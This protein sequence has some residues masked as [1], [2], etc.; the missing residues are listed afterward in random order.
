MTFHKG[1]RVAA[2]RW[3]KVCHGTV[4][5][6]RVPSIVWVVWDGRKTP[7]W[8]HTTSLTPLSL[9]AAFDLAARFWAKACRWEGFGPE[10]KFVVF[11]SGNPY[12]PLR[13]R[14]MGVFFSIRNRLR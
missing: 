13:D 12:A 2:N 10:E 8:S 14:A 11:S 7:D 9:V 4:V 1:Q 6:Q 5:E 3:G